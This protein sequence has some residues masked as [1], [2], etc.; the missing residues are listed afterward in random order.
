M[1]INHTLPAAVGLCSCLPAAV[2][3]QAFPA[4]Q[5][6][7]K[8]NVILIVLDDL[9]YGDLGCFG[10]KNIPTPNID[11]LAEDGVLFPEAY[12]TAS[13][14]GPSR[15]GIFTGAYQQRFG[16]Q[17]NFDEWYDAYRVPLDTHPLLPTIFSRNGYTTCHVGKYNMTASI[18]K[19]FDRFYDLI[20]WEADY[21]PQANGDYIGMNGGSASSKEHGVWGPL[22][23]GDEYMTDR[24][25]RHTMEFIDG[26]RD[27]PFF[28]YLGY[29]APHSPWQAPA[30]LRPKVSHL[31]TEPLQMYYAMVMS[32]DDNIG[33]LVD[34]LKKEGLYDN[35][36]IALIS[37]NGATEGGKARVGWPDRWPSAPDLM[38]SV[39]PFSGS[40]GNYREGGIHVPMIIRFPDKTM[41]GSRYEQMV[42]TMDLYPTL[43]GYARC[44]MPSDLSL[45]GV[46]LIPYLRD[47]QDGVPHQYLFW[48]SDSNGA[49]RSGDW[50]LLVGPRGN[51]LFNLREDIRE[52][53]D[54]SSQN[55][56]MAERL[57]SEWKNW[58]DALPEPAGLRY[59]KKK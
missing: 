41:S 1:K 12:A 24:L 25:T 22:R 14:S 29:N 26:H 8:P 36:V 42:S 5:A 44:R 51:A 34:Y 52:A 35:T 18:Y 39:A 10:G 28:I 33:K 16:M 47:A 19:T 50:K 15:C 6:S 13:I 11:R 17:H 3:A 45:N 7:S 43:A 56:E 23:P 59:R 58:R 32:L 49:I 4:K 9:G 2:T 27:K 46:N 57:L 55:P 37:D 20:G 40:K 21:Y 30:A 38:G 48:V 31:P 53:R 54:L